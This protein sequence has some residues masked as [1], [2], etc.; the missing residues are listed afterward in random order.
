MHLFALLAII[1]YWHLFT[2][3]SSIYPKIVRP[4]GAHFLRKSI[5]K[6][7]PKS[8]F[9][10]SN[11]VASMNAVL[12]N[13]VYTRKEVLSHLLVCEIVDVDFSGEAVVEVRMD[14]IS[15]GEA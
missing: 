1:L 7:E 12:K 5:S 14:V 3:Y 9:C 15:C 2:F 4:F 6:Q 11:F 13:Y 8:N 10:N